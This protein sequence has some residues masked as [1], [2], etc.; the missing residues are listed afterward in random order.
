MRI[1]DLTTS[2]GRLLRATTHLKE[3][4]SDS[5][6]E[7]DDATRIEFQE[8]HLEELAPLITLTMA[9]INRFS[10]SIEKAEKE[11][12]DNDREGIF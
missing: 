11:L 4:W 6:E 9:A 8:K 1:C 10:E 3:L 5:K 2:G 12:V 7:W